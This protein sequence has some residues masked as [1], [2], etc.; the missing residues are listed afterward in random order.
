[1][2]TARVRSAKAQYAGRRVQNVQRK[3]VA[4][5]ARVC[6]VQAKYGK[7]SVYLDL[8]D[9][10]NTTGNWDMYGMD[11]QKRYPEPQA[12]FFDRAADGLGRR[13]A[14]YAFL[15]VFGGAGIVAWGA[16]GSKQAKLPITIGPQ[17]PPTKGPGG[18]I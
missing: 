9:M 14:M 5:R 1:M 4:G 12:A 18:K 16:L 2:I 6:Q 15:G 8:D 10:D 17:E 11:D 7:D 13:E 3:T